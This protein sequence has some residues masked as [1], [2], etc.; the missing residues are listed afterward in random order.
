[1]DVHGG[2]LSITKIFSFCYAHKLPEYDGKWR[3]T[4]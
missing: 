4:E 2:E 3:V 1:M